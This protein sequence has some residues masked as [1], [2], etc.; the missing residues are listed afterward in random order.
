M[1]NTGG[2]ECMSLW[3]ERYLP[4]EQIGTGSVETFRAR[5]SESGR[6]VFLH[7]ISGSSQPHNTALLKQLLT[8]LYHAPD[9]KRLVIDVNETGDTCYVVT[10]SD[11]QC[12]YLREWLKAE[13]LQIELRSAR[14]QNRE[15]A[16]EFLPNG[17]N[18]K[19]SLRPAGLS[20]E[21]GE[22][23]RLFRPL[24]INTPQDGSN[25]PDSLGLD[26]K[27][28]ESIPVE[29]PVVADGPVTFSTPPIAGLA[30]PIAGVEKPS[31]QPAPMRVIHSVP[32]SPAETVVPDDFPMPSAAGPGVDEKR[33]VSQASA[34]SGNR[35]GED[36]KFLSLLHQYEQQSF[37]V[38][39]PPAA[40]VMA[41]EDSNASR[42][43]PAA[44]AQQKGP[45]SSSR[46]GREPAIPSAGFQS[47]VQRP[48]SSPSWHRLRSVL[49]GPD[50]FTR[51][52]L[53]RSDRSAAQ[54]PVDDSPM[55]LASAAADSSARLT[56]ESAG[57]FSDSAAAAA[58]PVRQPEEAMIEPESVDSH[59]PFTTAPEPIVPEQPKAAPEVRTGNV[60]PQ[61]AQ[62]K[63]QYTEWSVVLPSSPAMDAQIEAI[64]NAGSIRRRN[65]TIVLFTLLALAI[66]L[67]A[68]IFLRDS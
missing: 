31:P 63:R 22:L 25:L 33:S 52:L 37:D 56:G 11:P 1:N 20:R 36:S 59:E 17:T 8:C 3:G 34:V 53:G 2:G 43:R 23:S 42:L 35:S 27:A 26:G 58:V 10:E 64:R 12:L 48:A 7:R 62:P 19:L 29:K 21:P 67:L 6:T 41:R 13:S 54:R 45:E 16:R 44:P 66:L 14:E 65:S 15:D 60:Q 38:Q 49:G 18:D 39:P 68:Y 55:P 50:E 32:P 47:A 4:G 46:E 30:S 57:R 51:R 9:V 28:P 40:A 5:E 61:A 24:R